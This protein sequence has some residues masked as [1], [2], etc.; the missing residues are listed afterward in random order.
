MSMSAPAIQE[1]SDQELHAVI[2]QAEELLKQRDHERKTKAQQDA[3]AVVAAAQEQART[4]LAAVGLSYRPSVG[5]RRS[6]R[7][8]GVPPKPK[9]YQHPQR[10]E[11][12]W[13]GRGRKPQWVKEI[14]SGPATSR[15]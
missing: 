9:V 11:L 12:R 5:S 1:L 13:N 4:L 6:G 8:A 7:K 10:G 3:A 14:E 2:R 15:A